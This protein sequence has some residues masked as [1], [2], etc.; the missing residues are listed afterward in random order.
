MAVDGEIESADCE[1]D[2]EEDDQGEQDVAL[3]VER[4]Q[5]GATS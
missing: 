3:G 1:Q 4:Q 5:R 2:Y